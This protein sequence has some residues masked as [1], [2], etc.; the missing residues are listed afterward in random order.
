[1]KRIQTIFGLIAISAAFSS[2][3]SSLPPSGFLGTDDAKL[4]KNKAYP[5]Q[6]SWKNPDVD[7]ANYKRVDIKPMR[8]D[9]LMSLGNGV[10]ALSTTR[11]IGNHADDADEL[12]TFATSQ[13]QE[14]IDDSPGREAKITSKP[15][16]GRDTLVLETNLVQAVPGKPEA[17]VANFLVPF[18]ALLNRPSVGV[19]GRIKDARTGKTI[20]AFADRET[21][22]LSLFDTRKF[23]YYGTQ[24]REA[25]IFAEQI[26]KIIET[27]GG[28]KVSDP[29]FIS[30]INW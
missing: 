13:L 26:T 9:K 12:A 3:N 8:T 30:P 11:I 20:F 2:C 27:N 4:A 22:Q 14:K 7:L 5:F 6:R 15:G 1:M 19:E 21:P 10:D 28:E 24:R 17:Q 29:F 16:R 23:T 18:T 25:R